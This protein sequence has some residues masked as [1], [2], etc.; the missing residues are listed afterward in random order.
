MVSFRLELGREFVPFFTL[1]PTSLMSM[2]VFAFLTRSVD[3]PVIT[4]VLL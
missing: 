4:G 3:S 1:L 2:K